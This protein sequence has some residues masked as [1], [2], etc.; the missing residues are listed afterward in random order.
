VG[1]ADQVEFV[2]VGLSRDELEWVADWIRF[3]ASRAS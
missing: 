1:T 2:G 3:S